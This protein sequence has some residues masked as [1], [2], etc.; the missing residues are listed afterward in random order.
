MQ[1][2]LVLDVTFFLDQRYH[3][4]SFYKKTHILSQLMEGIIAILLD[5]NILFKI[6]LWLHLI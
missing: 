1:N 3:K 4:W 5:L 2:I 6:G